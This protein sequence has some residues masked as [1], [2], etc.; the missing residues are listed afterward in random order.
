MQ[1][2]PQPSIAWCLFLD[3]DGTLVELTDTPQGAAADAELK[4]LLA[5]V[6]DVLGGAVALVSG[7]SIDRLDELFAPLRLPAAGLHGVE[8]RSASG[9]RFGVGGID[10]ELDAARRRLQEFVAAHPAAL[11]EDKRRTLAIHFRREP[12]LEAPLRRITAELAAASAGRY[13]V[14]EG[15]MVF[16]LKPVGSSKATAIGDFLGEAPFLGRLPVFI[17]DDL[18]DRDGFALVESRGGI[19]I[20]V[21]GRVRARVQLEDP[22]AVHGLLRA[23]AALPS[24]SR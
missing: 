19:P 7:R 12:P 1:T 15:S 21:G 9:E 16:E 3:V 10:P 8:R 11:L 23:I 17:G 24:G 20:A 2:P 13:H 4:A 5:Q 14:Q 22:A 18:T 6:R